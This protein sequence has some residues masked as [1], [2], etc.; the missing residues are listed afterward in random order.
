MKKEGGLECMVSV[1]SIEYGTQTKQTIAILYT[2]HCHLADPPSFQ[3]H[4]SFKKGHLSGI[5][6]YV[7]MRLYVLDSMYSN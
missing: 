6:S 3:L 1:N 7:V 2:N 5:M 4:T